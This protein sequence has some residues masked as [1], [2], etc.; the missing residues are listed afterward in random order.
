MPKLFKKSHHIC[1]LVLIYFDEDYTV[2]SN[3]VGQR[4]YIKIFRGHLNK[5]I[6]MFLQCLSTIFSHKY[7]NNNKKKLNGK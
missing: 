5:M 4:K 7:N 1:A 6:G 3:F 2:Y